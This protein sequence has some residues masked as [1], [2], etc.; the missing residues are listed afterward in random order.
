[1]EAEQPSGS[2]TTTA[3]P[4]GGIPADGNRLCRW[5]AAIT[6]TTP[7]TPPNPIA[8]TRSPGFWAMVEGPGSVSPNG[9]AFSTRCYINNGCGSNQNLQYEADT[10][11]DRGYWYVVKM[12]PVPLGSV[13]INVFDGS[14][15]SAGSVDQLA[16]DRNLGSSA[17]FPTEFRVYQQNNPLDFTDHDPYTTT[18]ADQTIGSCNWTLGGQTTFRG[19]WR[20]L[21]TITSPVPNS[22]YLVNVRPPGRP[23]RATASTATPSRPSP[24]AGS[25]VAAGA[26]RLRDM[27]M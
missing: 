24:P 26:V 14:Y 18:P 7:P 15:N 25:G 3:T 23:P 27:G 11:A 8:A 21:C 16:G 1:M 12:P 22:L 19:A 20:R 17:T 9:D 13:D 6:T 5:Q 4:N 2:W 10:L